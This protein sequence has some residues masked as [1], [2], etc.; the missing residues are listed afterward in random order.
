V[1]PYVSYIVGGRTEGPTTTGRCVH[2]PQ[3]LRTESRY[4]VCKARVQAVKQTWTI[5]NQVLGKAKADVNFKR[6]NNLY[7][8]PHFANW[9]HVY[10]WEQ[11]FAKRGDSVKHS[12]I[13]HRIIP[14][15]FVISP[16]LSF[17]EHHNRTT[18]MATLVLCISFPESQFGSRYSYGYK[19]QS[20]FQ[21][22]CHIPSPST[23][24]NISYRSGR[25]IK[26][27]QEKY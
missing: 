16:F 27:N 1:C 22:N 21:C 12:H 2:D 3:I 9:K 6:I 15:R 14:T 19:I 23:S 7:G 25:W 10:S 18:R 17:L 4:D 13:I 24:F 11:K 26:I 5:N 8:F 20:Q